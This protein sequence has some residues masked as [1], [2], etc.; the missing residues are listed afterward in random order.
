V[1]EFIERCGLR[2]F[3][4]WHLGVDDRYPDTAR[5]H[6]TFPYGDLEDA[7]RCAILAAAA[8]AGQDGRD[9]IEQA[10]AHL[11]GMIEALRLV[12]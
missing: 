10:A 2:A 8:G 6:Y 11:Q 5:G 3:G 7:H 1:T 4:R 9:D 12:R